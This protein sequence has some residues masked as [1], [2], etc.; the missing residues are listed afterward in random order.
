MDIAT[1]TWWGDSVKGKFLNYWNNRMAQTVGDIDFWMK[2]EILG[3]AMKTS[4]D[5]KVEMLS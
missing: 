4:E 1:I 5:L 3:K 2:A